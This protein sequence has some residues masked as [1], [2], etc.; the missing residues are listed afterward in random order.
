[1]ENKDVLLK[2]MR[3]LCKR[4]DIKIIDSNNDNYNKDIDFSMKDIMNEPYIE[5]KEERIFKMKESVKMA[6]T[7]SQILIRNKKDTEKLAKEISESAK[8]MRENRYIEAI[9]DEDYLYLN[10]YYNSFSTLD[11]IKLLIAKVRKNL[12]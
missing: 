8:I 3:D 2:E 6:E 4:Y 10:N 5:I 11:L 9:R 1:M 7:T 12:L